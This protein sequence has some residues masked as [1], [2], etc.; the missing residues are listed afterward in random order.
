L[1]ET[2]KSLKKTTGERKSLG[3]GRGSEGEEKNSLWKPSAEGSSEGG[4]KTKEGEDYSRN[5]LGTVHKKGGRVGQGKVERGGGGVRKK[6]S[7]GNRKG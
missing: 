1:S 5:K 7:W 4:E 3:G 2:E 6:I